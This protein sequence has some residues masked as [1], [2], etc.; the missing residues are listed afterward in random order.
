MLTQIRAGLAQSTKIDDSFDS[1]ILSGTCECQSQLMIVLGVIRSRGHHGMDEV[2]RCLTSFQVA[3]QRGFVGQVD[4]FDLN[5]WISGPRAVLQLSWRPHQ[6]ADCIA[7]FEQTWGEAATNVPSYPGYRYAFRYR[8]KSP[9]QP[10][11][12]SSTRLQ[13]PVNTRHPRP[14]S[15]F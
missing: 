10:K 12:L 13:Y 15:Y 11:L 8:H 3:G 6:T 7:A 1:G 5:I 14:T 9:S 2:K 4:L